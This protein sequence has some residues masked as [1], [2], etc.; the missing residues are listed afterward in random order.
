MFSCL[1]QYRHCH[2]LFVSLFTIKHQHPCH[3]FNRSSHITRSR[4]IHSP[5][6][7][8]QRC[9]LKE[10]NAMSSFLFTS[11]GYRDLLVAIPP[12]PFH[13]VPFPFIKQIHERNQD[14]ASIPA[15]LYLRS[16]SLQFMTCLAD[17]EDNAAA[18]DD[19]DD[20][21]PEIPSHPISSHV[22]LSHD[23]P[24]KGKKQME[25]APKRLNMLSLSHNPQ[26][27]GRQSLGR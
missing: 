6:S 22:L 23:V 25:N 2:G 18:D 3:V 7:G 14:L 21:I 17:P 4:L 1:S 24:C 13:S 20:E 19:D 8:C 5:M 11:R 10:T 9:F 12:S 15:V 27:H 16:L 26:R